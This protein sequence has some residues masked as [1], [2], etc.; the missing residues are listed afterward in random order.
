M[1]EFA[2]RTERALRARTRGDLSGLLADLPRLGSANPGRLP[3]RGPGGW[4]VLPLV[5]AVFV[6]VSVGNA[7]ANPAH[8][9][10]F[11]GFVIPIGIV[12]ALRFGRRGWSHRTRA[13]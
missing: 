13:T 1:A 2:E 7:L 11:P 9:H 4:I 12:V 3:R 8:G 10:V 6:A 5:V